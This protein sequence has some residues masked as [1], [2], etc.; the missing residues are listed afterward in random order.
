M[1][2]AEAVFQ[3]SPTIQ[4]NYN[5]AYGSDVKPPSRVKWLGPILKGEKFC[6]GGKTMKSCGGL[7]IALWCPQTEDLERISQALARVG[8][9]VKVVSA[10]DELIYLSRRRSIDIIA[11]V[12]SQSFREPLALLAGTEDGK[13]ALAP[14]VV[15]TDPWDVDLYVR[16]LKLG[17]SDGLGLPVDDKELSRVLAQA[18]HGQQLI[19]AA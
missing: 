11:T 7:R 17:A 6:L 1:A 4:P 8:C 19:Q 10:R 3:I 9:I 15:F 5:T 13:S 18:A 2:K 16:A 14:L 12:L